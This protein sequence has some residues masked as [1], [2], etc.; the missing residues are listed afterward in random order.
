MPSF[1]TTLD[2]YKTYADLCLGPD[3]STCVLLFTDKY[4]TV[5]LHIVC[6]VCRVW[7]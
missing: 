3:S 2:S 6:R 5:P 4:V 7:C 1:V